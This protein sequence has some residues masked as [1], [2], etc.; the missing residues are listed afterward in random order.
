MAK[1]ELTPGE[2]YF[3]LLFEDEDP[4]IPV[5]QTLIFEKETKTDSGE[6]ILLFRYVPPDA[7]DDKRW[8]L[9]V[10]EIDYLLTLDQLGEKLRHLQPPPP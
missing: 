7:S 6:A 10:S 1:R 5:I 4:P 2:A 8:F 9:P 3:L